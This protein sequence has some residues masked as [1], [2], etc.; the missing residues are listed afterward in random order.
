MMLKSLVFVFFILGGLRSS[1][2]MVP[3]SDRICGKWL[4]AEKNLIVQVYK[5]GG[6]YRA[7]IIWFS[8]DPSYPMNEW[9]DSC[10]PDPALRTRKVLGMDVLRDL[11]YDESSNTW[12]EGMIYD[13]K[14]GREWNASVYIDRNGL[15]KVKGYWHFKFIGRT[16]VFKRV[17]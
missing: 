9:R 14:H 4:A 10:N 2:S 17:P 11:K 5:E 6:Q 3:E 15:L 13:A 7:K 16:L 8:D 12:E 1:A